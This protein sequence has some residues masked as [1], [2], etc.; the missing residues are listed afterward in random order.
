M[1]QIFNGIVKVVDGEKIG[2]FGLTTEETVDLSSPQVQFENYLKEAE[3]VVT[4][5]KEIGINKIVAVTH[6]G[7][8]DNPEIDNDLQLAKYV[9]G[10]DVIVG[11]HS[12]SKL[13]KPVVVN[14]DE[15]GAQK[16]PTVIVQAYQYHDYLGVVD[17]EFD[18]NGEVIGGDG[19]LIAIAD[20]PENPEVAALLK[21]FSAQVDEV[22]DDLNRSND[23]C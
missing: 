7:Y 16:N 5:F 10:I 17:I 11:G 14:E 13:E 3:K 8:D 22:K 23:P 2:I 4:Q 6:L 15:V 12:H 20:K 1:A 19:E 9:D 21:G 18:Q